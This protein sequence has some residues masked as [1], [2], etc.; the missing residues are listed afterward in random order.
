MVTAELLIVP[1]L[2]LVAG[3]MLGWLLASRRASSLATEL[4]TARV[5][6]DQATDAQKLHEVVEK[7]RDEFL[8]QLTDLH[9]RNEERKAADDARN[10]E[11]EA[12]HAGRIKELTD[13][14]DSLPVQFGDVAAK[15]LE[16]AQ[17]QFLDRAKDR[18]D[19]AGKAS[20]AQ[21]KAAL[22]PV[23]TTLKRYEANLAIIEKDR[24]GS[25][26]ELKEAVAQLTQGNEVVRRETARL[27]NVLRSSPKAR[28]RWGEEQLRSILEAAGLAENV[29]FVLQQSVTDGE[30]QSRPDCVITLPG[31]R[32]IVIDV[33]CPLT[34]F[35]AAFDEEDE[36]KRTDLLLQHSAT[37]RA[38]AKDLG[39]KGYWKRFD[40]SPEFVIM[41]VPGEH[42]LSAAAERAPDLIENAFRNGVIVA[43]TINM[44]ALAKI[45]AGMWRQDALNRQAEEIGALGREL[46]GRLLTMSGHVRVLGKNLNT[47]VGAYNDFVGSLDTNVLTSAERFVKHGIDTGGKQIERAGL[48]EQSAKS[49]RKLEPE[50]LDAG[51]S[52]HGSSAEKTQD[53]V[54]TSES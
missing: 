34:H 6:V 20:N 31:N 54:E 41:F 45:M 24:A 17:R 21:L 29:D 49:S 48:I 10:A 5:H 37:M 32:C 3:T 4:A 7:E 44:L 16:T 14:R 13:I 18:F 52:E 25:Y 30:R 15:A 53:A 47:A 51:M 9:A 50:N 19:E 33:K 2:A 22:L 39:Q 8:R 1:T 36:R 26:G 23:E 42:F 35:E 28:G 43:S 11:R 27:T 40:L 38:Y 46:Y 12:A